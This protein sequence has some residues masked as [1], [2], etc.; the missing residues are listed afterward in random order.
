[1]IAPLLDI[2]LH[3]HAFADFL[4]FSFSFFFPLAQMAGLIHRSK[5]KKLFPL[6]AKNFTQMGSIAEMWRREEKGIPGAE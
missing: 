3:E 1:L 5:Q 4:F 2:V 6:H